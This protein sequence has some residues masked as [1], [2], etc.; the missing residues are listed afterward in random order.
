MQKSGIFRRGVGH[1][2][3][4]FQKK[5]ASTTNHCWCQK[6]RVITVSC[7]IKLSTVHHLVLSP[8]THLTDGRTERQTELQHQ[9]H[10]LHYMQSHGKNAYSC[11]LL[12]AGDFDP[13]VGQTGLVSGVRSGLISRSAHARLQVCVQLL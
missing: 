2:W 11:P 8:Y 3:R 6:T 10:A 13:Q 9:Y 1:F 7:G 5:G 12:S 4:I